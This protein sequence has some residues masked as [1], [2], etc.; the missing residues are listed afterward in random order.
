[1]TG[2]STNPFQFTGRENDGTGVYFD[3]ARY[4][5]PTFQRFVGQDPIDFAGGDTN[6]YGYVSNDPL[7]YRDPTGLWQWYG[8]WGG[9]NWSGCQTKPLEDLTPDEWAKLS[10]PIDQQDQCYY[11]HDFCYAYCR[12]GDSTC[13][14]ARIGCGAT[15]DQQLVQCLG[16]LNGLGGANNP[17]AWGA[18]R[19]F[20]L[21][22]PDP[23]G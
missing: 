23:G 17:S 13:K 6:L 1:V 18:E 3:R 19:T 16:S 5:S 11:N 12:V 7:V 20:S 4:Y 10:P 8:C 15:C 14:S 2:S 22:H 9:P 21:Y